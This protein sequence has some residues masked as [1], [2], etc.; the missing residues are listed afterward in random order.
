MISRGAMPLNTP[1][2][3]GPGPELLCVEIVVGAWAPCAITLSLAATLVDNQYRA[4]HRHCEHTPLQVP[5]GR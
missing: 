4:T 5:S 1:R 2:G 3:Y